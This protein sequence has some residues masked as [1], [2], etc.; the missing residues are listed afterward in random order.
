MIKNY[1]KTA[2]HNLMHNKL[3]LSVSLFAIS[4]TLMV[5]MIA[6][7][8]IDTELGA[9]AP[10]SN[11][12]NIVI[13]ERLQMK[14][15]ARDT[16]VRIDSL[17]DNGIVIYDT[18][19]N[20]VINTSATTSTSNAGVGNKLITEKMPQFAS[21]ERMGRFLGNGHID[22]FSG[23]NKMALPMLATD[24]NY[25]DILDFQ[26]IEGHAY[27]KNDVENAQP[28]VVITQSTAEKYFGPQSSYLGQE[29]IYKVYHFKVIGV[30]KDVSA[31]RGWLQADIYLPYTILPESLVSYDWAY[32]GGLGLLF[33]TKSAQQKVALSK[34]LRDFENQL[35][36]ETLPDDF[37]Y[38]HFFERD[39]NNDYANRFMYDDEN[40][41]WKVQLI[42]ISALLLFILIP[43]LN[44]VGL[45]SSRIIER[46]DEI[47]VRKSFGATSGDLIQQFL[48]ENLV[49]TLL[50]GLLG[51]GFTLLVIQWINHSEIFGKTNVEFYPRFFA[52]S[53]LIVIVFGI[54]SGI[55]PALRSS[56]IPIAQALKSNKS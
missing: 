54:L 9:N 49:V 44:L 13:V 30:I 36:A 33:E 52:I 56:K 53:F 40:Q 10:M 14:K 22:V 38:I 48:T 4:F 20:E 28:V 43:T 7:A 42:G 8:F 50:G 37:D 18:I 41:F 5:L 23:T 1:L 17:I 25:F 6:I 31:S 46:S 12:E 45:N 15:Y 21:V 27:S 32:F 26:F 3:Y 34:E 35:M 24:A 11:K 39:V 29:I 19:K 47:A 55:I 16:E 2:W 51:L